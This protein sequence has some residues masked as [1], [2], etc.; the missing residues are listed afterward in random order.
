MAT[1]NSTNATCV[2]DVTFHRVMDPN[3]NWTQA[4]QEYTDGWSDNTHQLRKL[5]SAR[6]GNSEFAI[7]GCFYLGTVDSTKVQECENGGGMAVLS[8]YTHEIV[9]ADVWF[10]ALRN[11][12]VKAASSAP[13]PP[14][15][16]EIRSMQN[17]ITS[18]P[19]LTCNLPS[20]NAASHRHSISSW[21]PLL[22]VGLTSLVALS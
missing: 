17:N 2:F 16:D 12:D 18:G 22:A 1:S 10:C 8:S 4:R 20:R 21:L 9:D 13:K 15:D 14:T 6:V 3:Y 11:P 7:P 5:F 19:A